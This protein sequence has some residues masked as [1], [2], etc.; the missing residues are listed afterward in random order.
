MRRF[1]RV[2]I[3]L[4]LASIVAGCGNLQTAPAS[5]ETRTARPEVVVAT[6]T[7]PAATVEQAPSTVVASLTA[8]E[9]SPAAARVVTGGNVRNL[10]TTKG[11]VVLDQ[12]AVDETVLLRMRLPDD[13]WFSIQELRS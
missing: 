11:S 9:D 8:T 10:P 6:E 3:S 1:S 4:V 2:I 13:Q 7:V 12:V 5:N